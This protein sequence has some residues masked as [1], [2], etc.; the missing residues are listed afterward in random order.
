PAA[1]A[2]ATQASGR[3]GVCV[4]SRIFRTCCLALC[5]ASDE[6]PVTVPAG[7]LRRGD[8]RDGDRSMTVDG[9]RTDGS[10]AH[11]TWRSGAGRTWNQSYD[12]NTAITLRRRLPGDR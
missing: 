3:P 10:T 12:V 11:V 2:S 7:E 4:R 1:R 5:N 9:V 8:V 6:G